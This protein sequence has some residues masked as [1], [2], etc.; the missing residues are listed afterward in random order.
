MKPKERSLSEEIDLLLLSK[1]LRLDSKFNYWH[2]PDALEIKDALSCTMQHAL[3]LAT[4]LRKY[5]NR[6]WS[7]WVAERKAAKPGEATK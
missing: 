4:H 6:D 3:M 5:H 7:A 1:V 2:L